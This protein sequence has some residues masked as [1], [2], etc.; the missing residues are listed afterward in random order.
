MGPFV[1]QVG[2]KFTSLL[3]GRATLLR[4]CQRLHSQSGYKSTDRGAE[5]RHSGGGDVLRGP[6]D[7][8]KGVPGLL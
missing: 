3:E 5:R 7:L 4:E 6:S 8:I 2:G 1:S